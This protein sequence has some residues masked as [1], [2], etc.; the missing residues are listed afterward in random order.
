MSVRDE[1]ARL[2]AL[3]EKA[4]TAHEEA[5]ALR[6]SLYYEAKPLS[7]EE[8]WANEL[9]GALA[10]LRPSV[11]A[12]PAALAC[13]TELL[14]QQAKTVA[15]VPGDPEW[16]DGYNTAVEHGRAVIAKHFP[17]SSHE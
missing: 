8:T 7:Q 5:V 14:N 4:T 3:C 2:T 12:S 9:G 6:N 16:V 13:L 15:N 10:R 17:G 1:L 11:D